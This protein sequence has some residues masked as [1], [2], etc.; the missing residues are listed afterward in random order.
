MEPQV[1]SESS[2]T[3]LVSSVEVGSAVEQ[4]KSL[5]PAGSDAG[6]GL[7][8]A[9][10]AVLA[11]IGAAIKLGPKVLEANTAKA[12]KA[13]ELEMERLRIEREKS[14]DKHKGCA[15][16]RALLESRL[17]SLEDSMLEIRSKD[18]PFSLEGFDVDGLEKRLKKIEGKLRGPGRPKKEK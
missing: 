1:E 5:V 7:L 14:D 15:A 4:V 16:E 8:I 17:A 2:P 6:P 11:V 9:G 10:A 13:H 12:E 3:A 18:S